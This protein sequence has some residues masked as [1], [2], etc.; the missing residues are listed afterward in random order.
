MLTFYMK[1]NSNTFS[2]VFEMRVLCIDVPVQQLILPYE[3]I[4]IF[5]N[6]WFCK[7]WLRNCVLKKVCLLTRK[8]RKAFFFHCERGEEG[9][10][11]DWNPL[12]IKST[13]KIVLFFG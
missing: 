13:T 12:V 10:A 4:Q 2:T 3:N 8:G 11:Y 6:I 1:I 5:N 9:H 7:R